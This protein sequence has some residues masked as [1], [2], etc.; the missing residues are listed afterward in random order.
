MT[1]TDHTIPTLVTKEK[2]S[3]GHGLEMV[4]SCT[5]SDGLVL[6][7]TL[8]LPLR[9]LSCICQ[10]LLDASIDAEETSEGEQRSYKWVRRF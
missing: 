4:H 2:F 10:E 7:E 8:P 6:A 5:G 1:D 9:C 3:C